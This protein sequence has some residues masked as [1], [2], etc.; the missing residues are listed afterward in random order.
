VVEPTVGHFADEPDRASGPE[1][2]AHVGGLAGVLLDEQG[3]N[4]D[5]RF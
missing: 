2:S 4:V 3:G 1:E 5:A